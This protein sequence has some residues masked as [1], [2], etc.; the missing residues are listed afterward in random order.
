MVRAMDTKQQ[1][2]E[3]CRQ[4]AREHD[5]DRYY[6]SLFA[7]ADRRTALWALIA[8]NQE[9]AKTRAVVSEAMLGEIRLQWWR[10]A[11]EGIAAGTPRAHPVVEA[12][13][14]EI[15]DFLS[16]R[17]YLDEIIDTWSDDFG[18]VQVTLA[19]LKS[20]AEGTGGA[21]NAAMLQVL[22]TDAGAGQL[23]LARLAGTVW[24]LMGTVR[25]LP[26]ELLSPSSDWQNLV[27]ETSAVQPSSS[28]QANRMVIA[29]LPTVKKLLASI[30][31]D[32]AGLREGLRDAR[33][34]AATRTVLGLVP[35]AAIEWRAANRAGDDLLA[36][37][38]H[39]PGN[40]RKLLALIKY[41]FVG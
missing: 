28:D 14:S 10:E 23:D 26:H 35:F 16:I 34:D 36:L 38:K 40:A 29:V 1:N 30:G 20:H 15:H 12:L 25:A 27:S 24:S 31:E 7:P 17:P 6:I 39:L 32:L 21:L 41:H 18:D 22:N 19:S 3:Y 4:Q 8:F 9:V 11:L 5:V 37:D 33:N 2:I 13:A